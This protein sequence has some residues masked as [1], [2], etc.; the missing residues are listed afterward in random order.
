MTYMT[1]MTYMKGKGRVF[2]LA[3]EVVFQR[4]L[5][6]VV[7]TRQP[8]LPAAEGFLR[9]EERDRLAARCL[10]HLLGAMAVI[11]WIL[12]TQINKK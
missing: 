11:A 6:L 1:Y 4:C 7:P 5:W 9:V 12:N 10:R 2:V 3:R 8:G